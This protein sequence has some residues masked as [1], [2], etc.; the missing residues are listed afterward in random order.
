MGLLVS[1]SDEVPVNVFVDPSL[2]VEASPV[3]EALVD[4]SVAPDISDVVPDS[5]L[6]SSEQATAV[7]HNTQPTL[8]MWLKIMR[9]RYHTGRILPRLLRDFAWRRPSP[10]RRV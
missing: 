4:S 1:D 6:P 5:L 9:I 10:A 2:V 7:R 8:R 3:V